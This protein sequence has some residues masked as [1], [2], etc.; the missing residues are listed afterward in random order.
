MRIRLDDRLIVRDFFEAEFTTDL[1]SGV[2]C[3]AGREDKILHT[4]IVRNSA[5]GVRL[6]AVVVEYEIDTAG[7]FLCPSRA[8]E[9]CQVASR[10]QA[11]S[12]KI[13][14]VPQPYWRGREK[15][16]EIRTC[17]PSPTSIADF[18]ISY[19]VTAEFYSRDVDLSPLPSVMI[20]SNMHV[21]TGP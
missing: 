19:R 5:F 20:E 10:G 12:F 2:L 3:G 1:S 6:L 18:N 7:I 8:L 17:L 11:V 13:P 21:Q 15:R 16:A 9:G 14:E 4:T